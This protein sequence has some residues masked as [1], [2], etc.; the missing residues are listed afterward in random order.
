MSL[1]GTGTAF[2][3]IGI[4]CQ[5]ARQLYENRRHLSSLVGEPLEYGSSF[6]NWLMVSADEVPRLLERMTA[7]IE[8]GSIGLPAGEKVP[9]LLGYRAWMF[10]DGPNATITRSRLRQL[11]AKYEHLRQNFLDLCARRTRHFVL[12]NA[13]NNL[14]TEHPHL[15]DSMTIAFDDT[16][17]AR[18]RAAVDRLFPTGRNR[19][20]VVARADRL[21]RPMRRRVRVP[22]ADATEWEGDG[23]AWAA[24]LSRHLRAEQGA[25]LQRGAG[26]T[27]RR[28][29]A[30]IA[31]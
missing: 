8:A 14:A 22:A 24:V 31:R 25:A 13:Q 1:R 17:I 27:R 10:H 5:T 30:P 12:C 21:E 9:V 26:A 15:S 23:T 29:T 19:L 28:A 7:P 16:L 4:A 18:T 2:I 6:F 20:L 11:V 3:S